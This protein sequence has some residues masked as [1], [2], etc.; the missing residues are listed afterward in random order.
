MF[1]LPDGPSLTDKIPFLSIAIVY[2]PRGIVYGPRG[3]D[4]IGN[5]FSI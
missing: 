3:S 2:G 5:D 1:D 4:T